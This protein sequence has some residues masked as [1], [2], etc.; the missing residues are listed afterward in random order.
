MEILVTRLELDP[1]LNFKPEPIETI[2][3]IGICGTGMGSLAGM[4]VESG[5]RVTGSDANVYPP[6]SD[7][8][9]G[10]NVP[11]AQGYAPANLGHRPDLVVVGNVVT[12]RNPEAARL[13][14]LGLPYLSFPQTLRLFFL[15]GKKPLVVA[16][17]HGKTTTS[18]LAAWMLDAAGYDP[19]FMI[20]G[21]LGNYGRNHRL[22]R[23]DWFVV[24]G[25][26]YDTAFFDKVPK[27]I[28]YAPLVGILTSVEFDHA[29]IYPD[30]GAVIDA[31]RRFVALIPPQGRLVAWGD[32]PLVRELASASAAPVIYYG[33]GADNDWRAVGLETRGRRVS[34][35]VIKNGAEAG[36]LFSPLPGRHN[37]LNTLAAAAALDYA[38]LGL[39][40]A[41]QGLEG[42]RGVRRRQEV[43]GEAAGVI[44]IDDFAHHP[45]AVKETTAAIRKAYPEARLAAVF[46]P[47]TN[48]SRRKVFQDDYAAAFDQA[49]LVFIRQAPDLEK[50]PEG[51]RFSAEK[52]VGDL[53]DRGK[54]AEFFPDADRLL[55]RLLEALRPGDVVLIMSNGGFENIHE[56]LLSEL[57]K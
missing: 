22:G 54:P 27:F 34:F 3:L 30:L 18:S 26:E 21:I 49:D 23:G 39:D 11:V 41:A 56:R 1:T 57:R 43:R 24:E 47:R 51:D 9:A 28:H 2:H 38:G 50:A 29:D 53:R 35:R 48:T 5:Y 16:G 12:R 40:R 33:E 55:D 37:A 42:Y 44:V 46:E 7:F 52:L 10:M 17:T 15:Q 6:M 25:D 20:G 45:T 4:L 8:L 36:R 19:G 13:K 32:D 31:F 14:E